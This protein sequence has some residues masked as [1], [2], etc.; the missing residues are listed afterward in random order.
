MPN[1]TEAAQGF[2]GFLEVGN[3]GREVILN[4]PEIEQDERGGHIVFSPSE[5]RMLAELL[6]RHADAVDGGSKPT[7]EPGAE[8]RA[9]LDLGRMVVRMIHDVK[10][11]MSSGG[12]TA[13]A[14]GE[15]SYPGGRVQ[16][17]IADQQAAVAIQ[18]F[19][20]TKF[21]VRD[22]TPDSLVN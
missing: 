11:A 13:F 9:F 4:H 7:P 19:I 12:G 17:V 3:D 18:E 8:H 16:I 22:R 20:A 10:H 21:D 2:P 5:A 15:V 14:T 6:R 1:K